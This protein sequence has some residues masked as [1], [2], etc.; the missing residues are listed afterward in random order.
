MCHA[1]REEMQRF[2]ANA[3]WI[4]LMLVLELELFL[5][6][7]LI[8]VFLVFGLGLRFGNVRLMV[9]VTIR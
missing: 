6:L 5:L 1:E 9:G 8:L 2:T 4:E 3:I 7:L